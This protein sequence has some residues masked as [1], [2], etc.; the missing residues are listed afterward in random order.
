MQKY[1]LVLLLA[2]AGCRRAEVS[3]YQVKKT[4][5]MQAPL[6][7]QER[8]RAEPIPD[9]P[10]ASLPNALAWT[11]PRGWTERRAAGVRYATLKPAVGGKIDVSVVVLPGPAGGELANVN[12]WRGQLGLP[13]TDE[14]GL[15]ASRTSI[16]SKAGTVAVHDFSSEGTTKS[17]MV[18]ALLISHESTWFVKMIGDEGAVSSARADFVRVLQSLRFNAAN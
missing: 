7:A 13:P 3:R 6:F 17:R 15:G 10:A 11:L 4:A 8:P 1:L 18:A 14:R 5:E 9:S 2:V 16:R 12:R